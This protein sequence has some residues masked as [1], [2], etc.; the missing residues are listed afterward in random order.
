M[1]VKLRKSVVAVVLLLVA[2]GIIAWQAV[3]DNS[4]IYADENRKAAGTVALP[5]LMYHHILD[6]QS[7]LCDYIVSRAEFEADLKYIRDEGYTTI[8]PQELVAY[9]EEG[10]PLPQ[11]PILLTF[12]DGFESVLVYALPLL[13]QYHMK[14]VVS[15]VGAYT[16]Q[17]TECVDCNVNYAYLNWSEVAELKNSGCFAL[18]NH[19]YDLHSLNRMRPAAKRMNGE[20]IDEYRSVLQNDIGKLQEEMTEHIGITPTLFAYP[21]GFVSEESKDILRDMGFQVLLTCYEGV[22]MLSADAK[23]P[24]VLKRYNRAHRRSAQ[25][26]L[27]VR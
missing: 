4:A 10:T 13:K 17:F 6:R 14:A 19:T 22:N 20:S 25:E 3:W 9:Y 1:V 21:Y 8:L 2:L 27:S 11:K 23:P 16:D 18:G 15:I 12:D 5:V 24:Y 26:I 7:R